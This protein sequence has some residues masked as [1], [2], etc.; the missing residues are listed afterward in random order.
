MVIDEINIQQLLD[1]FIVEQAQL[2]RNDASEQAISHHL[3]V[4]F[5]IYFQSW[6]IDCEYNRKMEVVKRLIYAIS[7]DGEARER[8]VVTDI[9]IHKRMTKENLLAV[10]IQK[11]TNPENSLKELL[12]LT[13]FGD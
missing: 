8:N 4:K 13:A 5:E 3:A 12:K 6:H 11:T 1:E 10:E 7:P 9:I 2:L